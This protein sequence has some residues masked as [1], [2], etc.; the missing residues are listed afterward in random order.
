MIKPKHGK[1]KNCTI[2]NDKAVYIPNI[3]QLVY[4]LHL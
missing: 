1:I 2:M 4:Q 3:P